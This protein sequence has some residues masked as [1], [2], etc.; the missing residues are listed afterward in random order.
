MP[1]L[2]SIRMD[3]TLSFPDFCIQ[4]EIHLKL[5]NGPALRAPEIHFTRQTEQM[6]HPM[7]HVP[8]TSLP[9]AGRVACPPMK[10]ARRDAGLEGC[11]ILR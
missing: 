10:K 9:K 2:F 4:P 5:R 7:H 3:A 8:G 1:D 6:P 11:S